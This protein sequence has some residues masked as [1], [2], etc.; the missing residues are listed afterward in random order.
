MRPNN[1]EGRPNCF[2]TGCQKFMI[3]IV[4]EARPLYT[5]VRTEDWCAFY[6]CLLVSDLS[7]AISMEKRYFTSDFSMRS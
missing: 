6:A 5:A 7:E 3:Q 4:P 1:P 2:A